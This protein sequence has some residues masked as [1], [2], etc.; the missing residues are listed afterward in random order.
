MPLKLK[1]VCLWVWNKRAP[2]MATFKSWWLLT[3]NLVVYSCKNWYN[4]FKILLK[5]RE[6][7]EYMA[8]KFK[9][10]L[11]ICEHVKNLFDLVWFS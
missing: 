11:T 4:R 9:F 7:L 2:E 5:L 1:A 10:N 6:I 3:C 8:P